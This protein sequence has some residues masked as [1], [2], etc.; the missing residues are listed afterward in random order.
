MNTTLHL[1][2][3]FNAAYDS[4]KRI[5]LWHIMLE[6]GLPSNLIRLMIR[7]VLT[8]SEPGVII[9]GETSDSVVTTDVKWI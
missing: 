5:K 1:F 4:V 7:V 6:H 9:S 3:D 8:R 2:V